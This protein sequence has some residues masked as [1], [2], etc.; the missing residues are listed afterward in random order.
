MD[1]SDSEKRDL[2][3][4]IES[5]KPLPDQYRFRIFEKSDEI[6]LLCFFDT[7]ELSGRGGGVCGNYTASS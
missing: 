2:I 1:L 6:E 5:N 4:L 3:K 7:H